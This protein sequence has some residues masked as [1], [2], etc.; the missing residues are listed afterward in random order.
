MY[1]NQ[2]AISECIDSPS[3]H[4]DR[5]GGIHLNCSTYNEVHG[6]YTALCLLYFISADLIES[7]VLIGS[8]GF[9]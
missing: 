9:L 6:M 5:L 3:E 7:D 1:I 8:A 2:V 4:I